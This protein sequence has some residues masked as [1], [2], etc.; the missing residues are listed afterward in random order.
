M[1]PHPR[2]RHRYLR[3]AA[4]KAAALVLL[5]AALV[6]AAASA[7]A[8]QTEH[9]VLVIIDG[10]RYTEGLGDP[11]HTYVPRMHALAELGTIVEPFRNDG[12]TYTDHA[13]PAIWCGAWTDIIQFN[14]P[15][16]GGRANNHSKLPTIFEYYR[17]QLGRPAVDCQYVMYGP[18]CPWKAS[19]DPDYGQG[20]WP[21]YHDMGSNDLEVWAQA[22]GVLAG[23]HPSF[24]LLYL[25]DVDR[26]G[27]DGVWSAYTRSITVADSIVGMVW[28]YL[29]SDPLYAGTTTLI[30]TNDHGRHT[31]NFRY[32]GDGCDGCRTIELLMVGPDA[33][34]GF[35]SH[36]PRTLRDVTPTIGELLGF[37]TERAT[38]G[39]MS[40]I[41]VAGDETAVTAIVRPNPAKGQVTLV[42][43]AQASESAKQIAIYDVAGRQVAESTLEP[44]M[45]SWEWQGR[46]D[47][48]RPVAGGVYFARV[49]ASGREAT[50]KFVFVR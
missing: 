36:V 43:G 25:V 7:S 3:A 30:V 8:Y 15:D 16:C 17:K 21:T 32:H 38:G 33:T 35:V 44:N 28:D 45:L 9:V 10:L 14:D 4:S 34:A 26:Y 12:V 11:N 29:Q 48:G 22:R 24:L 1:N 6:V 37:K 49:R 19:F 5:F 40:E 50:V 41:L 47:G 31:S 20:Y 46:D 2:K 18:T 39:V 42:F 27:G 23:E 13:I